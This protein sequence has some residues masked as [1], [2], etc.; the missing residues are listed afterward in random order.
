V[1]VHALPSI[2]DGLR[3]KHLEPVG[4]DELLGGPAYVPC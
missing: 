2:L 1:L 4:L 3:A